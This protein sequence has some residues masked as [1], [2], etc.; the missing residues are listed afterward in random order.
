ME[1]VKMSDVFGEG[2]SLW[3]ESGFINDGESDLGSMSCNSFT[4]AAIIAIN[5]HDQH[6]ELIAKQSEQIK[7]L[8]EALKKCIACSYNLDFEAG[9]MTSGLEAADEALSATEQE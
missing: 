2:F 1:Q 4:D 7:M 5:R 9:W 3:N 8:R 6:I